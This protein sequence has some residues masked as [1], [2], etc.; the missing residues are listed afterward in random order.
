[1][2][3]L[4][5]GFFFPVMISS[6]LPVIVFVVVVGD[7]GGKL[8]STS[9]DKRSRGWWEV[10]PGCLGLASFVCD[11]DHT[12][13]LGGLGLSG[14]EMRKAQISEHPLRSPVFFCLP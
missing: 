14:G 4:V 9:E 2:P 3:A 7:G 13:A 6:H 10:A 5:T 8:N 11:Q 12:W 1:M